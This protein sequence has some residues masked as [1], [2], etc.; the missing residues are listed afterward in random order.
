[1]SYMKPTTLIPTMQAWNMDP[2]IVCLAHFESPQSHFVATDASPEYLF[3]IEGAFGF[4]Q[5]SGDDPHKLRNQN[6][7]SFVE[8]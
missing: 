4:Y 2:D 5:S 7:W 1:M 6:R 3:K 8:E